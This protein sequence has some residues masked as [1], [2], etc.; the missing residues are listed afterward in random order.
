MPVFANT[1]GRAVPGRPHDARDLLAGQLARPVEFVGQIEN[2]AAAGVRTFVEV[3]P[4]SVLTRLVEAILK[5][6]ADVTGWDCFALD[7]SGGKKPGLLDLAHALARLAARGHAGRSDRVGGR[8][9]LP[10]CR[11]PRPGLTVP[12]VG[13]NYVRPKPRSR[14]RPPT[15]EGRRRNH[16]EPTPDAAPTPTACHSSDPPRGS[17]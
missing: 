5:A 13:A 6:R 17:R 7:A 11:P 10:R 2:M 15:A 3:G 1:T 9:D 8:A 4:G 14:L 12:I 16:A